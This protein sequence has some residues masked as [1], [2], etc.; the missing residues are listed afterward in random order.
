MNI[1]VGVIL[2]KMFGYLRIAES[3]DFMDEMF[4]RKSLVGLG[5]ATNNIIVEGDCWLD[6]ESIE[7]NVVMAYNKIADECPAAIFIVGDDACNK[8][9]S[10]GLLRDNIFHYAFAYGGRL[11]IGKKFFRAN[12]SMEQ[13]AKLW[14]QL[15][16]IEPELR[17]TKDCKGII[18]RS[19]LNCNEV[20]AGLIRDYI[21][22]RY[23]H[24][25]FYDD[26]IY[27]D[28]DTEEWIL[29]TLSAAISLKPS[30]IWVIGV[31][32]EIDKRILECIA[33]LQYTGFVFSTEMHNHFLAQLQHI[34][35]KGIY[36]ITPAIEKEIIES[37]YCRG[38][39]GLFS[40][41]LNDSVRK[42]AASLR[43]SALAIDKIPIMLDEEFRRQKY[44]IKSDSIGRFSYDDFGE[45]SSELHIKHTDRNGDTVQKFPLPKEDLEHDIFTISSYLQDVNL[46]V[47]SFRYDIAHRKNW[48]DTVKK[49]LR[50]IRSEFCNG[51]GRVVGLIH[52]ANQQDVIIADVDGDNTYQL[53]G[54][55]NLL[56]LYISQV[57]SINDA[58]RAS[59]STENVLSPFPIQINN[60]ID[61]FNDN[62]V[63]QVVLRIE[64]EWMLPCQF[65]AQYSCENDTKIS[66]DAIGFKHGPLYVDVVCRKSCE[67]VLYKAI[68]SSILKPAA[69]SRSYQYIIPDFN[70]SS[71]ANGAVF[72]ESDKYLPYPDIQMISTTTHSICSPYIEYCH[73]QRLGVSNTKSA[74]GSIMSRNGS[75]NIGSHV[76]AALSHNVG[77][78]PDD[79]VLYQYIQHRMDYIATATTELPVWNQPL[80]FVGNLV[81]TF[82]MQRH[83]LD[84]ITGSEGLK[85]YQFQNRTVDATS[86][87]CQPN[88]I[89]LHV[90]RVGDD[91]NRWSE[92]NNYSVEF[93]KAT[94]FISYPGDPSSPNALMKDL[95]VAI[96]GGI[97]GQ[98][99]FFTILENIL[100]NAAKHEW[101]KLGKEE[102][103]NDKQK[104]LDVHVDFKDN[105]EDGIVEVVAW[106]DNEYSRIHYK[107]N[108]FSEKVKSLTPTEIQE[109]LSKEKSENELDLSSLDADHKKL[110]V[111]MARSFIGENGDLHK[112]NWGLAEMRISAGYLNTVD[113]SEI[114]GLD[115]TKSSELSL[116]KP[117]MVLNGDHYCL[118]YH[119]HIPKPRELLVVVPRELSIDK[120]VIDSANKRLMRYGVA[121]ITEGA[122]QKESSGKERSS[123]L[124]YA[125]VLLK[126]FRKNDEVGKQSE[127][128]CK[129]KLPFRVITTT[130]A[131]LSPSGNRKIDRRAN[132]VGE[133]RTFFDED[134][135]LAWIANVSGSDKSAKFEAEQLLYDIY[136]SWVRHLKKE[137]FGKG[138]ECENIP[139]AIDLGDRSSNSD[140]NARSNDSNAKKSLISDIDVLKVVFETCFNTAVK[141]FLGSPVGMNCDAAVRS[142]LNNLMNL[143]PRK[144]E[145]KP[146]KTMINNKTREEWIENRP[147]K[148]VVMAQLR[149]WCTKLQQSDDVKVISNALIALEN[150]IQS[151]Y[152]PLGLNEFICFIEDVILEQAKV[153]L[154][155][156]EETYATLPKDVISN[157]G[158]AQKGNTGFKNGPLLKLEILDDQEIYETILE[159]D[160]YSILSGTIS[161]EQSS[162]P[163]R[164]YSKMLAYWRHENP[165]VTRELPAKQT[166]QHKSQNKKVK[167]P[168][169][170]TYLEPLSGAQSY[171]NSFGILT[172]A[173]SSELQKVRFVSK[174]LE[175][176]L[177]RVLI[178]DER[179]RKFENEHSDVRATFD[180]IGVASLDDTS[181]ATEKIFEKELNDETGIKDVVVDDNG[182]KVGDYDILVIHQGI[183]DKKLSQHSNPERINKF[184]EHIKQEI[185]Y[186]VV[187]TG[188]G[189]PA[190]IP[191]NV[192]V[193][194]FSVL[195][196]TLFKKYPEKLVL[197]DAI[198]NVLPSGRKE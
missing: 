151:V 105:P 64:Q 71:F 69:K 33:K 134:K 98:H 70:S 77:T 139:I 153:F 83:L 7:E 17:N 183:I 32:K 159:A 181:A 198:M 163:G 97:V 2:P 140:G 8:L 179:V 123:K 110:Q 61:E 92:E 118:G 13:I 194:P 117:V 73:M 18:F 39:F 47:K 62:E 184:I 130:E 26:I 41:I 35:A 51:S 156:Y 188:R 109:F 133:N 23:N 21:G 101:A 10:Q 172:S 48:D 106:T 116:I 187:T 24:L 19:E 150:A 22:K 87:G 42:R 171:V 186:V 125:Y 168:V 144:V 192:R 191:D 185:R 119:F 57:Q 127:D 80:S 126:E 46:L 84:Y 44:F 28:N 111:R 54:V 27:H 88:T 60:N 108:D 99:A 102:K 121:V 112:E 12:Y 114:G 40:D 170:V 120:S 166:G 56:K 63:F 132:F 11:P 78:M 178:I 103:A 104:Y 29:H 124:S 138:G 1:K 72:V 89:R 177:V 37:V 95:E 115:E 68:V 143:T 94:N 79:R 113:I 165:C 148:G 145:L 190:N 55:F 147:L 65:L 162:S 43:N 196:S 176:G 155:K 136:L 197:V 74:I 96:P 81:K 91:D 129:W 31:G 195:E 86:I 76:L 20:Q 75:H 146:T 25:Q 36:F 175:T 45:L 16:Q 14:R 135:F 9:I 152:M 182:R 107:Q 82:L 34:P 6:R 122:V 160:K 180:K 158:Y 174:L 128:M 154:S 161:K 50:R 53:G 149:D 38:C 93:S 157:K 169:D 4:F 90:R 167:Q 66:I 85:A 141:S 52:Y 100:R 164:L 5:V 137:R 15:F 58:L 30:V 59:S 189:N 142:V 193:V 3:N 131:P 49:I 67:D 173:N